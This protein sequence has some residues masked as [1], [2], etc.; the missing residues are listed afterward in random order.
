MGCCI[1]KNNGGH[2]E[3]KLIGFSRETEIPSISTSKLLREKG[4]IGLT[5]SLIVMAINILKTGISTHVSKTTFL[6][7]SLQLDQMTYKTLY[8]W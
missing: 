2:K 3:L 7:S 5:S 4:R 6:L 1:K 8:M